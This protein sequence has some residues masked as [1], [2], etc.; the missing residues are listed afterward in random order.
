MNAA[1]ASMR[2]TR[3][4][5]ASPGFGIE[6]SESEILRAARNPAVSQ[7]RSFFPDDICSL[8]KVSGVKTAIAGRLSLVFLECSNTAH[9]KHDP[10]FTAHNIF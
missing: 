6:I 3:Y 1:R 7:Y 8:F 10:I 4:G 9:L 2:V 5:E